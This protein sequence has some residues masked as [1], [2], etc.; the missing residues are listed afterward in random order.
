MGKIV[1][2]II[3]TI[4]NI[5]RVSG[6][7][8]SFFLYYSL[9][10]FTGLDLKAQGGQA[11]YPQLHSLEVAEPGFEP[12]ASDSRSCSCPLDC[13]FLMGIVCGLTWIMN[14]KCLAHCS[15]HSRHEPNGS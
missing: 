8:L 10:H 14:T 3:E 2:K 9:S 11:T 5:H 7:V 13:T 4:L 6:A 1:V 12:R 15:T